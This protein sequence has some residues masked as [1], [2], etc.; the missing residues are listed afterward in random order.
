MH[1]PIRHH[2]DILSLSRQHGNGGSSP[3]Y[4]WKVN[5]VNVGTLPAYSYIPAYNDRVTCVLT[6]N[7]AC[8]SGNPATSNTITMIVVATNTS[9]TG[10]VPSPLHLCF[11]AS[12]TVTVAGGGSTFTVQSGASAVYDRRMKISYLYGTT[13]LPGGYMHGYITTTNAYCGSLPPSMVSVVAGEEEIQPIP[14]ASSLPFI[15]YPNPTNGTFTLLNKGDLTTAKIQVDIF[16]MRGN[17]ILSTSLQESEAISSHYPL[18]R[19]DC[20]LSG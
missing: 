20:I 4:Q 13:V 7:Y 17:R 19:R 6:S 14:V 8:P 3:A 10:N 12:N 5:G 2:R 18:C 16:D 9:A 15:L 11:D 1:Q